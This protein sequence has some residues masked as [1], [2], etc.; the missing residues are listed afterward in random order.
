[1][2]YDQ[3]GD[4]RLVSIPQVDVGLL[5]LRLPIPDN[6]NSGGYA[7]GYSPIDLLVAGLEAHSRGD[8]VSDLARFFDSHRDCLP[9]SVHHVHLL[10][11]GPDGSIFSWTIGE[12]ATICNQDDRLLTVMQKNAPLTFKWVK[13][14][15]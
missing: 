11:Q 4:Y 15:R 5:P 6:F 7:Y 10:V 8:I 9:V 12:I 2:L 3:A 14:G 1:M 13:H